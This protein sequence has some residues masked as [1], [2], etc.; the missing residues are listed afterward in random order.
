MCLLYYQYSLDVGLLLI[1]GKYKGQPIANDIS[2]KRRITTEETNINA[3]LDPLLLRN[4]RN[5]EESR[6]T[7][8]CLLSFPFLCFNIDL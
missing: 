3:D 1:K 4:E 2:G 7:M 6:H 8:V 5:N